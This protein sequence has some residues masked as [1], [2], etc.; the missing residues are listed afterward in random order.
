MKTYYDG[1]IG[2]DDNGDEWITLAGIAATDSVWADF[3]I[4]WSRMLARRYPI[5]PY[6]HMVELLGGRDPFEPHVGWDICKKQELIQDA[7]ILLSHMN[8]AE[9]KMVWCSINNSAR[10]RLQHEGISVPPDPHYKCALT[11]LA[12]T[13]GIYMRNVSVEE[14]EPLY[15]FYDRGEKF[16]TEFK[17]NWLSGRTHPG[18]K[19]NF[20]NWWDRFE[21]VLDLDL[22]NHFPLQAADMIAWGH[23]R[24]LSDKERLF[25]HLKKWLIDF[26]PSAA[27]EI[28]E[29]TMRKQ[30]D[31][32]PYLNCATA[33]CVSSSA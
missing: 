27:V 12:L 13:A 15:I 31:I 8:K 29:E 7:I 6:I 28:T 23:S 18:E 2:E 1:S 25:S 22:P 5:A 21:N 17:H 24:A 26:V 19:K 32:W 3:D 14:R 10:V 33:D 11:C 30:A 16:F 20:D 9:V 4:Q